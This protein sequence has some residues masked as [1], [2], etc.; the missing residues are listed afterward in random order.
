LSSAATSRRA[1][2]VIRAG[3]ARTG[4]ISDTLILDYESRQAPKSVHAGLRG[5][6]IEVDLPAA[7]L[8][9]DDCLVL[10]DG[11]LAEIVAAPEA[12]LEVRAADVTALARIAFHLGDRHVPVEIGARRLR[13][14]REASAES[15]LKTLGAA[16]TFIEAPFEPE[17]GAY[18][19][20]RRDHVPDHAHGHCGHDHDLHHGHNQG[21]GHGRP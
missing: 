7:R 10:D 5:M 13:V 19:H 2:G 1:V 15:L 20:D 21:A 18:S 3:A 12:L 9:T 16:V 11:T 8:R 6:R 14:R 17:G 4:E